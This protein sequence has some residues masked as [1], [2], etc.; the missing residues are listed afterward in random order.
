MT[1]RIRSTPS[2]DAGRL[3]A[4]VRSFLGEDVKAC[5]PMQRGTR[6]PF[7]QVGPTAVRHEQPVR[8]FHSLLRTKALG[9]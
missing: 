4:S 9:R 5:E 6:S 2:C 1:L 8:I 3:V 7:Y